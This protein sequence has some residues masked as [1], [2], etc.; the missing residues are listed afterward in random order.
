MVRST[1]GQTNASNAPRVNSCT[2]TAPFGSGNR[3]VAASF[4]ESSCFTRMSAVRNSCA[5]SARGEIGFGP[6]LQLAQDER[7]DFRRR[8]QLAAELYADDV[9][10]GGIDAERKEPQLVLHVGGPAAHEPLHG[11][12]CSLGL[13]EQAATR[14]FADDDAP[15]RIKAHNRGA[16][17]L[18]VWTRNT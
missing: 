2:N 15:V 4:S 12:D 18:A 1:M 7:G 17:R 8:E 10:A 5:S 9:L 14:R 16:K 13:R 3:N 11:I 6:I